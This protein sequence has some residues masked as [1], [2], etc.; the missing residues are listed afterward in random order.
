MSELW[1][2]CVACEVKVAA[3]PKSFPLPVLSVLVNSASI[4]RT[5]GQ[6][7]QVRAARAEPIP[8]VATTPRGLLMPLTLQQPQFPGPIR[9]RQAQTPDI[10]MAGAQQRRD[11]SD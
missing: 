5:Q 9:K 11:G 7:I 8:G 3:G 4:V 1:I 10:R 6:S 2:W